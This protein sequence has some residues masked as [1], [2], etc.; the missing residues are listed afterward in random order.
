MLPSQLIELRGVDRIVGAGEEGTD[1]EV[2]L[3]FD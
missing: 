3:M 2:S 1:A